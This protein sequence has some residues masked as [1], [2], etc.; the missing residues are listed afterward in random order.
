MDHTR[1]DSPW[2]RQH[3]SALV[4]A[5]SLTTILLIIGAGTAGYV[6]DQLRA[7]GTSSQRVA[8]FY[9]ADGGIS[10]ATAWF[11][12]Q[13]YSLPAPSSY[14]D[15][16]VPV[17]LKNSNTGVVLPTTHP[18]SYADG[19]GQQRS[20]V[21]T[22]FNAA[23][24][25]RALGNGT[26]SVTAT[27]VSLQPEQWQLLSTAHQ[28]GVQQSVGAL[29][30]RDPSSLFTTAL[31]GRRSVTMTGNAETDSYDSSNGNYGGGNV[32]A[33][34]HVRSN[35]PITLNGN[36][37]VNG[38]A[39]PGPGDIVTMTGNASVTGS[40]AP[41]PEPTDFGPVQVPSD[42]VYLGTINLSGNDGMTINPGT[43]VTSGISLSGNAELVI[44][45]DTGPVYLYVTGSVSA[46]GNGI[47]TSSG[48]ST[49][50]ILF[51]IGGSD[52]A[53]T[54]NGDFHGGVYAPASNLSVTGNGDIYG[55]FVG[56]SIDIHGNG[57]IH[58]DQNLQSVPG[59]PGKMRMVSWWRSR[60]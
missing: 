31:F 22:S 15:S 17:T 56:D 23:L 48:D 12:N 42:A 46:S 51:Q 4:V 32:A 14:L 19:S 7:T 25:D 60:D 24:T 20:D 21:V 3:G 1:K 47:A 39:V 53:I 36:A 50:F 5:L 44:N 52:V 55:S 13:A 26:F 34:G 10:E 18:N 40:T 16:S 57:G 33:N 9:A 43:Y 29:L 38:N 49:R 2:P 35:G 59:P 45:N 27:L 41:A 30:R 37:T 58:Y 11:A 54:G 6:V 8:A 28:G